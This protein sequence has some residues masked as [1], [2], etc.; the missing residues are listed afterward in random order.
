MTGP[1]FKQPSVMSAQAHFANVPS[2]DIPRSKF[3]RSH[4]YKTTYD[5]GKLVPI[6]VDEVLPGDTH[7][8][9]A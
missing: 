5:A 2:A 1:Y 9:S 3:D 8:V 6:Y 7:H 4:A